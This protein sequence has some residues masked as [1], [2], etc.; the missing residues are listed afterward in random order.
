MDYLKIKNLTY[1]SIDFNYLNMHN[2]YKTELTEDGEIKNKTKLII[3]LNIKGQ[4]NIIF[5]HNKNNFVKKVTINVANETLEIESNPNRILAEWGNYQTIKNN[6]MLNEFGK[7]LKEFLCK[8]LKIEVKELINS[9]IEAIDLNYDIMLKLDKCTKIFEKMFYHL[10]RRGYIDVLKLNNKKINTGY[11]MYLNEDRDIQL[12]IYDKQRE[13]FEKNGNIIQLATR[14]E[15]RLRKRN[16]V[17][18]YLNVSSYKDLYNIRDLRIKAGELINKYVLEQFER[19]LKSDTEHLKTEFYNLIKST[20]KEK[21]YIKEFVHRNYHLI[22]DDNQF[23]YIVNAVKGIRT[24]QQRE[25][26]LH[27]LRKNLKLEDEKAIFYSNQ[28]INS[29]K[30]NLYLNMIYNSIL[31]KDFNF[32]DIISQQ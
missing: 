6:N 5:K 9:T 13:A 8:D 11:V 21:C 25:G 19:K 17:L 22:I 2:L 31:K 27:S 30:S 18:K 14:F 28:V 16:D 32:Q 20:N 7:L 26:L 4:N 24:Q 12:V 1:K 3:L 15:I 29:L 23:K 10:N